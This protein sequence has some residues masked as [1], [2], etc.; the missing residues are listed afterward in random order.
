MKVD[1]SMNATE[2]KKWH[3]QLLKEV[4][5]EAKEIIKDATLATEANAK[6]LCPVDQGPLREGIFSKVK[7]YTGEVSTSPSTPYAL[8]VH[9]GHWVREGQLFPTKEGGFKRIKETR[10]IDGQPFLA[11]AFDLISEDVEAEFEKLLKKIK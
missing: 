6:R 11:Q 10:F 4:N 1:L 3:D 9:E 8:Y 5:S 7:N 2:F